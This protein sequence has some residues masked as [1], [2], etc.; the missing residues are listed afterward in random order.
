MESHCL[1]RCVAPWFV[2][3]GINSQ[4]ATD[5]QVIITGLEDT[6][7]PIQ[8]ARYEDYLHTVG[9][10]VLHAMGTQETSHGVVPRLSEHMG[11]DGILQ[12]R[13]SRL[14]MTKAVLQVGARA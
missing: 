8:I 5:E 12:R 1:E 7:T 2:V 11:A 3:R 14:G 9:S 13:T 10:L 4:V 6:V